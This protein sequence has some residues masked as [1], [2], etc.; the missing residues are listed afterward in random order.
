MEE[1]VEANTNFHPQKTPHLLT[2]QMDT[3]NQEY[4]KN[5]RYG[6]SKRK[7]FRGYLN[8]FSGGGII[9]ITIIFVS[10]LFMLLA[11]GT[12][13]GIALGFTGIILMLL[14]QGPAI[15]LSVI[16]ENTMHSLTRYAFTAIPFFI[17]AGN[18]IM[19]GTLMDS[20]VRL[21][22][23]IFKKVTGGVG[24]AVI[25]VSAFFGAISGSSAASAASLGGPTTKALKDNYPRR[26]SAGL[27]ACG[28]TMGIMIPPSLTF[29]LIGGI[30][31]IPI[32]DLFK[33][34]LIPGIMQGTMLGITAYLI[35]KIKGYDIAK[36]GK[37]GAQ[38]YFRELGNHTKSSWPILLMPLIILGGIF[39]GFF[40]PTEIAAV[41]A[42][43]ALIIVTFVF[44]FINGKETWNLFRQTLYTSGMIYLVIIGAHILLHILTRLGL[45][46]Q[47]INLVD[48]L[49]LATWQFLLIVNLVL[50]LLG[51]FFDGS[52]MIL[53]TAPFLFPMAELYGINP[54]HLGVMIT[55]NVE[56]ATLTPPI[57]LNLFVMS[58]VTKLSVL[59]VARGVLPFY[60][61]MLLFL[62]M[63][64][65][66]PAIS[67][68][69]E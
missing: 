29:I 5:S 1:F 57:G 53:L 46:T 64:T 6:N 60:L 7:I 23:T 43:Y 24:I 33:A 51:M 38:K 48:S 50:L 47:L 2:G 67:L 42:V 52:G 39:S 65:Y 9:M 58:G 66:I 56:I 19:Q 20:I 45:S 55:A 3:S 36:P 59:Q 8:Y 22:N 49:D 40:T 15:P 54:I 31:Q 32:I 25:A 28:G 4:Q 17:L 21:G 37:Q 68:I 63:I 41:S 12:Q 11:T 30:A 14:Q 18:L 26:F 16:S 44:R 61:T 10:V 35:S 27:V 34:G 62:I 69:F 13:I